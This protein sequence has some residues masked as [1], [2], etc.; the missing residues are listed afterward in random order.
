MAALGKWKVQ[1][2]IRNNYIKKC[3]EFACIVDIYKGLLQNVQSLFYPKHY[4]IPSEFI[5]KRKA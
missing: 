1:C 3:C 4:V 5:S 2:V